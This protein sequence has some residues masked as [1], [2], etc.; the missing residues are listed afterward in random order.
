MRCI[1]RQP[2]NEGRSWGVQ[3]LI[4]WGLQQI[5]CNLHILKWE[6]HARN[7]MG[8]KRRRF[9]WPCLF[10]QAETVI[11]EYCMVVIA[12]S[13]RNIF[14]PDRDVFS[15]RKKCLTTYR[16]F[17]VVSISTTR[18]QGLGHSR[19][20]EAHGTSTCVRII[21][22]FSGLLDPSASG[23]IDAICDHDWNLTEKKP[24]ENSPSFVC[25]LGLNLRVM[26]QSDKAVTWTV[27]YK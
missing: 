16:A 2:W 18:T 5:V 25:V 19:Y 17:A 4:G 9:G 10:K 13:C 21:S 3:C 14:R 22:S 11:L 1:Q 6:P 7:C 27:L 23:G 26:A 15:Y 20:G 12:N 8:P 24:R